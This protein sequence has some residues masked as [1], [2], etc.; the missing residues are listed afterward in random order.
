MLV[1]HIHRAVKR[2]FE[3]DGGE[4][5]AAP[6]VRIVNFSI[7]D[8]ARQFS[9]LMSPLARLLD[10]LSLKYQ[11]LF[12]I[13]A[14]NQNMRAIDTGLPRDAF[15]RLT[16]DELERLVVSKLY[17]DARHRRLLSPAESINGITVG[18]AHYDAA[19]ASTLD[20]SI[21][22][23]TGVLPSPISP[24]G[25]GYRRAIK[26]ELIVSA[27]RVLF[28]EPLG[29]QSTIKLKPRTRM[30]APG[31]RVAA[32]GINTGDLTKT[33]FACGTSNAAALM[34]RSAS[35]CHDA[36]VEILQNQAP[37]TD[38]ALCV[39]PL[40]KAMLIHGCSW[41]QVGSRLDAILRTPGNG[42]QVRNWVSRWLGYGMPDITK[43]LECSAQRAS[44]IG[45]GRLDDGQAHVFSLPLPPSLGA[46]R[47]W[48]KLTVTLAW[49]SPVAS[50]TQRYR[51]AQLWFEFEDGNKSREK[52]KQKLNVT[53]TD[54]DGDATRR[55]TVQHEVFEG[56]RAVAITDGDTLRIKV[57]CRKDA[58]KLNEQVGYGLL[59]SM[60]VAEGVD[61]PIY[62]EIRTR[63]APA[64]EIRPQDAR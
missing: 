14:G 23:F 59:V 24:F 54:A 7:G 32:P 26:P 22:A 49:L 19:G 39:V 44:V 46:R 33:T 15:G 17:D 1:D 29:A 53:G 25:S 43:A 9:Q 55:G 8:R 52:L 48:R 56:D 62:D 18:A 16:D 61:L 6:T 50:T 35:L 37:G 27:G 34:S 36:L 31:S 60:E 3:G 57:N 51:V 38:S 10:W 13:S 42:R 5:A 45:F 41:N 40:I 30:T 21:D 28:D 11:V 63:I 12:V 58:G 2:L 64:I 47:E 20:R 4:P